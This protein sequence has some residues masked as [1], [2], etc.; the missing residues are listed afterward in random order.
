MRGILHFFSCM[1][2]ALFERSVDYV[3]RVGLIRG[4][5]YILFGG[6]FVFEGLNYL[7]ILSFRVDYTWFGRMVS[8]AGV[9]LM[10]LL[11]DRGLQKKWNAALPRLVW[12]FLSFLVLIDF[13]GDVLGFY[14]RWMWYDRIAHFL[15]GFWLV[16]SLF[17]VFEL[18]YSRGRWRYPES[19]QYLLILGTDVF[20]AVFYEIEEY[21]E[22]KI[23]L[24]NRLGNG[25]DTAN[26][27]LMNMMGAVIVIFCIA[28]YRL[29]VRRAQ[30]CK[31][32]LWS[33]GARLHS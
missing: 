8:T 1:I 23:F 11:M 32:V 25:P 28:G 14:S 18:F 16:G 21:L 9:F 24:T 26:D 13:L 33:L 31:T 30:K 4:L 22:D 5:A 15:S 17:L 2:H 3:Q 27:L 10:A 29:L 19:V 6:L 7:Q 20:L 12:L